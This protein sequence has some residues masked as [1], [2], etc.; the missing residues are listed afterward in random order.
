MAW[1]LNTPDNEFVSGAHDHHTLRAHER[2]PQRDSPRPSAHAHYMRDYQLKKMSSHPRLYTHVCACHLAQ[3]LPAQQDSFT[4]ISQTF[5]MSGTIIERLG[6]V[7]G[8]GCA[9]FIRRVREQVVFM[10]GTHAAIAARPSRL[11]IRRARY[12]PFR[13]WSIAGMLCQVASGKLG[14]VREERR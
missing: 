6:V 12:L 13:C 9:P 2:G 3:I 7:H 5:A 11:C 10:T 8:R 4:V 1:R 14:V